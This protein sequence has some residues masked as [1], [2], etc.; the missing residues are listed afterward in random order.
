MKIA[1]VTL[2][3]ALDR[4]IYFEDVLK[5]GE[6]NRIDRAQ[7]SA[8]GKGINV[9]RM[10]KK[11][12]TG[13]YVYGF[14]GGK[15]GKMLT[16]MLEDEGIRTDFT[17]TSA[18]TR[19]NV[20][21]TEKSGRETEIN[22]RGGPVKQDELCMLTEKVKKSHAE[23]FVIS[24]STPCGLD[25]Y[26]VKRIAG[27]L[28]MQGKQVICDVSGQ[29]LKAAVEIRP[30]LI[31]PN[32]SEFCELLGYQ[33]DEKDYAN[34]AVRF[35]NESGIEVLLTLG[36]QGAV[37]SGRG[38]NYAIKNPQIKPKGFSGAGDTF[39]AGYIY[40]LINEQ[41]LIEALRFAAAASY[42]KVGLMGT[43]L[44]DLSLIESNLNKISVDMID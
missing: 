1:T 18:E 37:Y 9:S 4:S 44:P 14:V 20:K 10:L 7:I 27:I 11:L 35:Y 13:S 36:K 23:I 32:R 6:L 43:Q 3:P 8:G 19:M 22:E 39:L 12:D 38:G 25:D 29:P 40:S 5:P 2:N 33:I 17:I 31:K 16:E 42:S 26:T 21:I 34:E 41:P 28:K 15:C 30:Y 24:G